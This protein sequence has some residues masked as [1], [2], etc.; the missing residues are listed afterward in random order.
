MNWGLTL[1]LM[2]LILKMEFG[3]QFQK[4]GL[5]KSKFNLIA[6]WGS[7]L[8]NGLVNLIDNEWLTIKNR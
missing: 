2:K 1:V 8:G 5:I 3:I 6:V 4:V 7:V